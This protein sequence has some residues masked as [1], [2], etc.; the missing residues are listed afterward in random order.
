MPARA[1]ASLTHSVTSKRLLRL[2][3]SCASLWHIS[4]SQGGPAKAGCWT[5]SQL[6]YRHM[7]A[8]R[9]ECS[10]AAEEATRQPGGGADPD[11][12]GAQGGSGG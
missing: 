6:D 11:A 9:H 7:F 4:K 8:G 10:P 5:C 1:N 12:A 2:L 3:S